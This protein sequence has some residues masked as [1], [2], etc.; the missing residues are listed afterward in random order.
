MPKEE[1]SIRSMQQYIQKLETE[2]IM[3]NDQVNELNNYVASASSAVQGSINACRKF[4]TSILESEL[5]SGNITPKDIES[6]SLTELLDKANAV[7]VKS[8]QKS[9]EMFVIFSNKI[10]EKNR[11]IESLQAQVS[12]LMVQLNSK[13]LNDVPEINDVENLSTAP[14]FPMGTNFA[15]KESKNLPSQQALTSAKILGDG[16]EETVVSFSS[17]V[18]TETNLSANS[19]TNNDA[20]KKN[21]HMIDL[22]K[23]IKDIT[24][25]M[26][27]V[28]DTIGSKGINEQQEIRT[29]ILQQAVNSSTPVNDS[30]INAATSS[31]MKMQI[32]KRIKIICG[33][34]WFYIFELDEMGIRVYIEKHKKNPVESEAKKLI[35]EHDNIRHGYLIKEASNILKEKFDYE[36]VSTSRKTNYIPLTNGKACIPDVICATKGNVDYFEVECGN[37]NQEDFNDK[38]NKY[39]MVSKTIHFIVPQNEVLKVLQSQITAWIKSCGGPQVLKSG[40]MV[41]KV[42]TMKKLLEKKWELVY[43]MTSEEPILL[44]K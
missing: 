43:D 44:S 10:E 20:F 16:D 1:I 25:V 22:N 27:S 18:A 14:V 12:Q 6:M 34:R 33:S 15:N 26:W 38:C 4:C 42:T 3:K 2:L 32:V 7:F 17:K 39:R 35:K 19:I 24:P 23:F 11:L 31:L 36:S 29:H 13:D 8:Q 9:R 30:M 41:V 21:F 28:I 5:A 37:H 40:D